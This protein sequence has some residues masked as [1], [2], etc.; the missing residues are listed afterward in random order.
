MPGSVRLH[1]ALCRTAEI[2]SGVAGGPCGHD[3]GDAPARTLRAVP[4]SRFLGP[5]CAVDAPAADRVLQQPAR[6]IPMGLVL[7]IIVLLLLI[8]ALPTW[9]HSRTW[10]YGP[11]GVLGFILLVV[12]I[13]LLLGHLP[14]GF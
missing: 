14:R 13:L 7:L 4:S 8:G 6:E 11:S 5:T 3:R 12:L 10:G 1:R 9:G 2:L